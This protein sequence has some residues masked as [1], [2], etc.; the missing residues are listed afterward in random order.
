MRE[1]AAEE[2]MKSERFTR[3]KSVMASSAIALV[4]AALS[5]GVAHTVVRPSDPKMALASGSGFT[6]TSNIY[7]TSACSGSTAELYPG[8]AR[9]ICFTV[10][11]NL[12]VPLTVGSISMTLSNS[13]ST[14]C[15]AGDLSLP[16]FSGS[17]NVPGSG[18]ASTAGIPI[19]LKDDGDQSSQCQDQTFDFTYTGTAQYTDSTSTSL[20]S[21]SPENTAASGTSVTFTATVTETDAGSDPSGPA[22]TVTFYSC[23]SSSSC[24]SPTSTLGTETLRSNGQATFATSS[25]PVGTSYVEAVYGGSDTNLTGSTSKVVTQSVTSGSSATA[26]TLTASPN[27]SFYGSSVTF[28]DTVSSG[29]GMPGGTATFYSCTSNACSTKTSLGTRTLASGKATYS[30]SSLPKGTTYVEAVY[31]G[32]GNYLGSTSHVMSQVGGALSTSS[33]LTASPNPS[34]YRSSVTLSD[35]ASSGSGTPGGAATFYSCTS[36]A[37]STKTSLGTRTLASGKATYSTSS[38][39]KGTTYVEAVYAGS[40]NYLGSTSHVMSQV[41][42]ALSTSST[43]TASPNPSFYRSSVTLSDT[44]SS[45]SGTP[46]GTATFY[47]CTSNACSTKTSLGTRTLTSGKATYSTSSLPMGTTYVEA[48]YAG[49]GNY[50]GSTSNVMSQAV[51]G[52]PGVCASGGY[53]TYMFVNPAFPF[54]DGTNGNDFI[55]AFGG[56]FRVN[57]FAGNDCIDAGD[58]HHVLIDGDGNDGVAAGDGSNTIILGN[59]NDKVMGGNGSDDVSAGNGVDVVTLGSGSDDVVHLGS[60]ADTVALGNGSGSEVIVGN[61]KDTIAVGSGSSN[62]VNLGSGADTVAIH[63][64]HDAIDGGAGNDTVYLGSGTYNS[65]NGQPHHTNVCHLPA[66]PPNYHGTTAAYHHDTINNCTVVSP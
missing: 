59:G 65:Y 27:P 31:A 18:S 7:S 46:G 34:F 37:C 22:G 40:G 55:Y 15:A 41:V 8:T 36:N 44:V 26:S 20:A 10:Q 1:K 56:S 21:S 47:S 61:G 63:G 39:P 9:Y 4:V 5:F 16:T 2:L 29:S 24:S 23:P 49:S 58:A 53:G 38:L 28:G 11:N 3:T 19:E 13:P 30:T 57:G 48:V 43:L 12:T 32:S 25:L 45:G 62:G 14:S 35:T 66:P 52:V 33:T 17:L 54:I 51:V 50:L 64:S 60:G 6:I 42:G